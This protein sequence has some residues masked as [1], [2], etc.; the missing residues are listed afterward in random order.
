MC[1]GAAEYFS[2]QSEPAIFRVS[3]SDCQHPGYDPR[4]RHGV[5]YGVCNDS[6]TFCQ[7]LVQVPPD[8]VVRVR[9][10]QYGSNSSWTISLYNRWP[11]LKASGTNVRSSRFMK[12]K[13]FV[14]STSEMY[15]LNYNSPTVQ[16]RYEAVKY[17]LSLE[18][19][20]YFG[21]YV[22]LHVPEGESLGRRVIT[23]R[24][25]AP[26]RYIIMVTFEIFER[27]P[28]CFWEL[29][30]SGR[31]HT[32][33]RTEHTYV[34]EHDFHREVY[35]FRST[36]EI[37]P[38]PPYFLPATV[39]NLCMKMLFSFHLSKPNR[40]KDGL[41]NCS[42]DDYKRFQQHF[43][44]NAKVECEDGRDE[45]EHCPFSSAA[46]QGW[47]ASRHKCYR[48]LFDLCITPSRAKDECR[49]H[50]SKVASIKTDQEFKD[51]I[52]VFPGRVRSEAMIAL[53][54]GV[55][56]IPFMYRY[57]YRW[58]DN[59]IMYNTNHIE[60]N[61]NSEL[62]WKRVAAHVA[63]YHFTD[64]MVVDQIAQ[65]HTVSRV[66]CEKAVKSER[67]VSKQSVQLSTTRMMW[68]VLRHTRQALTDCKEG[69]VTHTFL[70][71][72]PKSRCGQPTCVY[73]KR[74]GDYSEALPAAQDPGHA[75]AMY[76][77]SGYNTLVH[78]TLVCD[79]RWDCQDGS[80]ESFCHHPPCVTLSCNNGQ[81][82][83][84]DKRCN[85]VNDCLDD[86]DE[87]VCSPEWTKQT[88]M[89]RHHRHLK[90]LIDL[91]G[92][93]Y[94]AYRELNMSE[95]CPETHYLCR[96]EWIY[97]LPVYT[98]CNGFKDC[99]YGEDEID[100]KSI[101]C[102][103]LYRCL[104]S[105]VCL[106]TDYL[107]DGCAQCPQ[108]DDEWLC[109]MTCPSQCLCQG[110]AF[111]CPQPF[112][113]HLFPQL[114]YLDAKGSGMMPSDLRNNTYIININLA[115]CSISS[116]AGAIFTNVKFMDLSFN[117]MTNIAVQTFLSLR[118]LQILS[119]QGN[120]LTSIASSASDLKQN[121]LQRLDLSRTRLNVLD[122]WTLRQF[123]GLQYIN[124]SHASLQS[125]KS[126]GFQSFL[127]LREL[128]VRGNEINRFPVDVFHGLDKLAV[129]FSSNYRLCCKDVLLPAMKCFAPNH[130]LF[131]CENVIHSNIYR[132]TFWF[133]AFVASIGNLT[134]SIGHC[135]SK[136]QHYVKDV[137]VFM[138]SLHCANVCIGIYTC[139]IVSADKLLTG[140]Y[141]HHEY[142]W[143]GSAACKVAGF[144][145]FLSN[146]VSI[147]TVFLLSLD[148]LIVVSFPLSTYRFSWRSAVASCALT[149]FVGIL[150]A[151]MPLHSDLS[152]LGRHDQTALCNLMTYDKQILNEKFL[153][154]HTTVA[155]NCFI[156][157]MVSAAQVIIYKA[158]VRQSLLINFNKNPMYESV[159]I[160]MDIAAVEV[161][162]WLS[163]ITTIVLAS[164][165]VAGTEKAA[166]TLAALVLPFKAAVNPLLCL[167]NGVAL[168]L[169]QKHEERLLRL[170]KSRSKSVP[171]KAST[172]KT[173]KED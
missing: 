26:S 7:F 157:I 8:M 97:C 85:R 60:L 162:V 146:E 100:C 19:T 88:E 122:G 64:K 22:T 38:Y 58:F 53:H 150:L 82:V 128:D 168:R 30:L 61:P 133:V 173:G 84:L 6:T 159:E 163:V 51:F 126:G 62:G 105:A 130:F 55:H 92:K 37:H 52:K 12:I 166:V 59:T 67:V 172:H 1:P 107:C 110:H 75:V 123:P 83:A 11:M 164:A 3:V 15:V 77:C 149:W 16:I 158:T 54:A 47:V 69:H 17:R 121:A 48:P 119:L 136:R 93:G 4:S 74:A 116:F 5:V 90:Y 142:S 115:N 120:P 13:Q 32:N 118:N 144:L 29:R 140:R 104:D 147:V 171:I 114:R 43:H 39:E 71:C 33:I 46:C 138:T 91:D 72:D 143:K 23:D 98:R 45:T 167:W 68:E 154:F 139:M 78:Y 101:T 2:D 56:Y 57:F 20:S 134:C 151:G 63:S 76:I 18:H 108:R 113:A 145:S 102:A 153:I 152:H 49:K 25:Q 27:H 96:T 111:Q 44:C 99:I 103:G 156:C 89:P 80:D 169:K 160:V 170:L 131:S 135:L 36:V 40:L 66:V 106:H 41:Y 86:T 14:S 165:G 9:I 117:Q 79:F 94:F 81:C 127:D 70:K 129:I 65:D 95:K 137:L 125:V 21:G 112:S 124:L 34:I 87:T 24:L 161:I 132:Y 10:K 31:E 109:D 73:F 35:F 50:D 155:L 42:V 148:H 28:S 141:L